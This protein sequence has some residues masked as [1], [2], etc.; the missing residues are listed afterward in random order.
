MRYGSVRPASSHL[1]KIK[2]TKKAGVSRY[3][4]AIESAISLGLSIARSEQT[5]QKIALCFTKNDHQ[6]RESMSNFNGFDFHCHEDDPKKAA[7]M[8]H[9]WLE[10]EHDRIEVKDPVPEDLVMKFLEHKDSIVDEFYPG[11]S[12]GDMSYSRI[13]LLCREYVQDAA[14]D[15][16]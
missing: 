2:R 1:S 5:D 9:N 16:D 7:D 14:K 4:T 13:R 6:M 10:V 3:N 11:K 8:I 15:S 12:F